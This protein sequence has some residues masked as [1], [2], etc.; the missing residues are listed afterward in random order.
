MAAP[1]GILP[2]QGATGEN[3]WGDWPA[4][5]VRLANPVAGLLTRAPSQGP[6]DYSNRFQTVSN[7]RATNSSWI[8]LQFPAQIRIRRAFP[9]LSR[10]PHTFTC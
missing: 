2:R 1:R 9:R 6:F 5:L 8:T 10:L 4:R 3:L 7:H